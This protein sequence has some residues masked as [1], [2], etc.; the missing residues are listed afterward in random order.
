MSTEFEDSLAYYQSTLDEEDFGAPPVPPIPY[1]P[2]TDAVRNRVKLEM[3]DPHGRHTA[4]KIKRYA[5]HEYDKRFRLTDLQQII[6]AFLAR[7]AEL[8]PP[9]EPQ[10][11]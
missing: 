3:L 4:R 10:E 8:F 7:K 2:I 9:E 5:Y 1:S 11:P 6:D